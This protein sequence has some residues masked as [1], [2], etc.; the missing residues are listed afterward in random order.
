MLKLSNWKHAA[1]ALGMSLLM[2]SPAIA[3]TATGGARQAADREANQT[4]KSGTNQSGTRTGSAAQPGSAARPGTAAKTPA[5]PAQPRTTNKPVAESA[6][7][8]DHQI[9]AMLAIGNQ[10]EIAVA[11]SASEQLQNED[12]KQFAKMLVDDH[13]KALQ[14]LQKVAPQAVEQASL[15]SGGAEGIAKT[16]DNARTERTAARTGSFD[17][18]EVHKQIAERCIEST[19]KELS[20]KQGAEA[21]MCF[22]G[23]QLVVHQQTLDKLSVFAEYASP[24]LRQTIEESSQSVEKHLQEAK[25]LVKQLAPQ[26]GRDVRERRTGENDAQQNENRAKAGSQEGRRPAS[27]RPAASGTNR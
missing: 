19:R 20:E 16:G 2:F 12:V 13:T 24:E 4:N 18:V 23:Q 25:Q 1:T 17:P 27:N 21:D 26:A 14:Q 3:Q 10:A 5:Q 15:R 6:Q 11:R 9:A 7:S 22:I 8:A